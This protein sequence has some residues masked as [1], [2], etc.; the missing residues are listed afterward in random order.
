[1]KLA[2]SKEMNVT[3]DWL[4]Q[5]VAQKKESRTFRSCNKARRDGKSGPG[6][7][8]RGR[9]KIRWENTVKEVFG[10]MKRVCFDGEDIHHSIP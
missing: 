3:A 10:A 1:M 9:P 8:R 6:N 7:R 2:V 4:L 5:Y